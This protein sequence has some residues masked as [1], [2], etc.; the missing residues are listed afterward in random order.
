[1]RLEG[2]A[3][4]RARCRPS[5]KAHVNAPRPLRGLLRMRRFRFGGKA[6]DRAF[7]HHLLDLGDRLRRVQVLGARLGAVHDGVATIEP[8]R[9]FQL[10]E[11]LALGLVAAI[12]DP[13]IGLQ[14][15]GR[16]QI[17]L[18]APPLTGAGGGAAETKDA[19]PQTVELGAFLG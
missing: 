8:E 19:F 4:V 5:S 10:V 16:A 2:W 12:G 3:A 11:P 7:D 15:N 6:L 17:A 18:A 1:M 13:A 9:I 14:Q